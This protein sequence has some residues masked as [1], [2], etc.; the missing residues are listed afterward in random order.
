MVLS[1]FHSSTMPGSAVRM[2]LRD[3]DHPAVAHGEGEDGHGSPA[4]RDDRKTVPLRD[5]QSADERV[6]A[7]HCAPRTPGP[8]AGAASTNVCPPVAPLA[9]HNAVRL[10]L[11]PPE[12]VRCK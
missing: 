6:D 2:I 10:S 4:D 11:R 8:C 5:A 12:V 3:A 9:Y 7:E 1:T